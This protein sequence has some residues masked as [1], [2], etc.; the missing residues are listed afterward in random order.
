M[1]HY[2][3]WAIMPA[4]YCYAIHAFAYSDVG[5]VRRTNEDSF[6]IAD[7]T[8]GIG[9][10][11]N[12]ILKFESGRQG[13]LFAVADGMGGAAAGE[14]ASRI[15]LK[16][17]YEEVLQLSEE[18]READ[19]ELLDQIL[20]DAV[21][22]ANRR[23]FDISHSNQDFK[24]MGTTL[25]AVLELQGQLAIGQIGDSR[26]YLIRNQSIRQLTRD[27]SL[28]AQKVSNGEITE[29]QARQHPERNILLQALGIGPTVQLGIVNATARADDMILLCSDGLH[30]QMSADEINEIVLYSANEQ[31]ACLE[32]VN[33]A[34]DRGGP[35][36]ITAV[37]VRFF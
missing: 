20:I 32:L 5:K 25:T 4:S 15:G 29:A 10:E 11:E 16:S 1:L 33:L 12:G 26:A 37:L 22:I 9:I 3:H 18:I 23:I 21:G 8:R 27:Q 31:D 36:N 7:L 35:D 34:N 24:G 30:A 28:V 17:V 13:A 14:M 19:T 6:V 2:K